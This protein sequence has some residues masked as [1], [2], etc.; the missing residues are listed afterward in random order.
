V[1]ALCP[2]CRANNHAHE[3]PGA[4][5]RCECPVRVH[6]PV[7][8]VNTL[9]PY[10][11]RERRDEFDALLV[12]PPTTGGL[13]RHRAKRRPR[14]NVRLVNSRRWNIHLRPGFRLGVAV[15]PHYPGGDEGR[16]RD[17]FDSYLWAGRL[18]VGFHWPAQGIERA[19]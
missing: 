6:F 13:I 18:I 2:S 8:D 17:G 19:R 4:C 12:G 16:R 7:W 14:R 15:V 11:W 5:P 1:T 10:E 9:Y 3:A